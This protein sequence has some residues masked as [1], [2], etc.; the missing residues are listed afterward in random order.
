MKQIK[1]LGVAMATVILLLTSCLGDSGG[2][3][4]TVTNVPGQIDF[5]NGKFIVNTIYGPFYSSQMQTMDFSYDDWVFMSFTVDYDSE[6]NANAEANGYY[7]VQLSV[8]PSLIPKVEYVSMDETGLDVALTSE[9]PL[10]N[11]AVISNY[12]Y[13]TY[14]QGYLLMASTYKSLTDQ[15]ND[16]SMVFDP[17]QET[18]EN[19]GVNVYN[20]YVRA[21]KREEGKSPQ[22]DAGMYNVYNIKRIYENISSKEKSNGKEAFGLKFNYV[23]EIDE[24]GTLTWASNDVV[25]FPVLKDE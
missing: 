1:F 4:Q 21:V 12:D 15:K 25:N 17:A 3:T 13:L 24:T 16:F 20:V 10:T 22:I 7:V 2:N 11:A 18:E 19:N 6:E 23:K 5:K 9:I 8:A 14:F